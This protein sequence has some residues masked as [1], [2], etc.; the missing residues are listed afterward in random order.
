MKNLNEEKTKKELEKGYENAE[1]LLKDKEKM[2]KFLQRLEKKLKVIPVAGDTLSM[3]PTMISL[4]KSYVKK[5]YT[6]IPLGTIIA[7]IS[8]L[9]YLLS[10]ADFIPDTIPGGGYIDDAAVILACLKLVGSDVDDYQKWR[11]DHNKFLDV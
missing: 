4:I 2:E 3:V 11:K 8:A 10:P 5:E 6:D 9:A 7:I 1:K